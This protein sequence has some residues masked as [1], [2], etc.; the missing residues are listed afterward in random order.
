M[1]Q[2]TFQKAF[3]MLELIFVIVILGIVASIGSSVIVKVYEAYIVQ[4]AVHNASLKTE[5]AVNILANRLTYRI[6][7]S[8]V[9]HVP[10]GFGIG[11]MLPL[12]GLPAGNADTH[13]ALEWIGYEND[14]FST[15]GSAALAT[16]PGWSGFVDLNHVNTNFNQFISTASDLAAENIILGHLFPNMQN[17]AIYFRGVETYRTDLDAGG[18][19]FRY[20]AACMHSID[21]TPGCMFPVNLNAPNTIAFTGGGNRI[22]VPAVLAPV[23]RYTE[24]YQLA[25]SAY[26]VAPEPNDNV[27]R[28]TDNGTQVWDLFLYTDY[29]PWVA[30]TI[31]T[32]GTR[33]L[34]LP[35]V[36]VFRFKKE[37]NS[38]RIKICSIESIGDNDIS[39]CKEKAVIR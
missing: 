9:A 37:A 22:A 15:Q 12:A 17:P 30:N 14:G 27:G 10:G 1:K 21:G 35:N 26:T 20:N 32:Q 13:R 3:S 2:N 19:P 34:L 6:D 25:A 8:L 4:R 38:V 18:N 31:Y 11:D 33:R 5:L 16:L 7:R 39:I 23:M 29:Q 24:Q 36:S 28:L